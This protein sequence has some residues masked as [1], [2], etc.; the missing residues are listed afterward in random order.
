MTTPI[1]L[2]I[3]TSI[4]Y[5]A[6]STT[7]ESG[8]ILRRQRFPWSSPHKTWTLRYGPATYSDLS[9]D[10]L[11][12]IRTAKGGAA[13]VSLAIPGVGTV[14]GFY[15]DDVEFIPASPTAY[16]ATVTFR[17]EAQNAI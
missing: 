11:A 8:K 10:V 12:A 13:L 2:P 1:A 3:T 15:G 17:A 6:I 14:N 9:A 16:F 7:A 5:E 4:R